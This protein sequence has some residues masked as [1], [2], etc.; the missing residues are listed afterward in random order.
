MISLVVGTN[1]ERKTITV[2]P[3]QTLKAVLAEN[4]VNINGCAL[5]LN[6]SLIAG[7]DTEQTFEELGV[8]DGGK[9]TLIAVI[10]ADSAQ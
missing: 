8:A 7:I 3:D 9:A 1:T 2:E 10:K 5:N 4:N 6:G